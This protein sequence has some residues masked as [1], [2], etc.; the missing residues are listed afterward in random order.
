MLD[1]RVPRKMRKVRFKRINSQFITTWWKYCVWLDFSNIYNKTRET[2]VFYVSNHPFPF[3]RINFKQSIIRINFHKFSVQKKISDFPFRRSRRAN[4]LKSPTTLVSRRYICEMK[5][6]GRHLAKQHAE[7]IV[8]SGQL[9]L[10]LRY[11]QTLRFD[12]YI[13]YYFIP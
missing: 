13:F 7:I 9:L 5:M 1:S 10:P 2:Y 3:H 6:H 11:R 12:V 4:F 8:V